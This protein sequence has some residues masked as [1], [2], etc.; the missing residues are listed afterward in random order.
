MC[1]TCYDAPELDL[2]DIKDI[3]DQTAAW[4]VE[5]FN[6][7]GGEPFMRGDVEEILAYAVRRGFYVTVTT[8]GTLI[9]EKRAQAIAAIPSDRLHFNISL[10]GRQPEHDAIRSEGMWHRAI[11]GFHRIRQADAAAGNARRKILANTIVHAQNLDNFHQVLNEQAEIGFDGVQILNLFRQGDEVPSEATD[12]WLQDVH[13]DRLAALSESLACRS[14][15]QGSVGYRIQ[16][17]PDQLRRIPAYYR[18]SLTP[19]EA[20]CWAGWKELYINADGQ[21]IM[22]DGNLDFVNGGF[23]NARDQTLKELW[24]SP[25]LKARREVVKQCTTPCVQSCYLREESDSARKLLGEVGRGLTRRVT[26]HVSRLRPEAA[27]H[28]DA[29]LRL[30]LSDVCPCGWAGCIIPEHRWQ[31]LIDGVKLEPT[32]EN[33]TVLRDRGEVDFGRGFMGFEVLEAVIRD[34]R[35]ARIRFGAL[36]LRWRGEPLIHPEAHRILQFLMDVIE[37]RDVADELRV[38]TDGRF[39]S[40]ALAELAG[41]AAPQTWVVDLDRGAEAATDALRRLEAHRGDATRIVLAQTVDGHL[42]VQELVSRF[43]AYPPVA[44]RLPALGDALWLRRS[45]HSNFRDNAAARTALASAAALLG[46]DAELGV[47]DSPRQCRAPQRSP[48]ISWDGKISLCTEDRQ[49]Q[50]IVGDVI[51]ERFSDAWSGSRYQKARAS[52]QSA[53]T[54]NLPLCAGCPMPWSPNHD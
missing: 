50:Q 31:R 15:E 18:E 36:A 19:L 42:D 17:T 3:I 28:P 23:G 21:A 48:I 41:R 54:P 12:L 47:E 14:E 6:P 20:P 38:E 2:S 1:T 39:L 26:E 53:G 35:A 37:A 51:E 34:L 46:I 16:N 25:K 11:E 45:D 44:G 7:L 32:A 49:L 4:G 43:D 10:D 52:C 30:E 33:W 27:H 9:T 13:M 5:V 24:H 22:C 40:D 8:N 29:T